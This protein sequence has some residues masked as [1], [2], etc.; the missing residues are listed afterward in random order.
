MNALS[1]IRATVEP[2]QVRM[3]SLQFHVVENPDD[4][5]NFAARELAGKIRKILTKHG[6]KFDLDS[7]RWENYDNGDFY[8]V[9]DDENPVSLPERSKALAAGRELKKVFEDAGFQHEMNFDPNSWVRELYK[10]G[11]TE[12]IATVEPQRAVSYGEALIKLH[13]HIGKTRRPNGLSVGIDVPGEK[14]CH[15]SVCSTGY[16]GSVGFELCVWSPELE[17][18]DTDSNWKSTGESYRVNLMSASYDPDD[19]SSASA[20]E[21]YRSYSHTKRNITYWLKK[22]MFTG[23]PQQDVKVLVAAAAKAFDPDFWKVRA[24]VNGGNKLVSVAV[25]LKAKAARS[26]T[27]A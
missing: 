17:T 5:S 18:E 14:Q 20:W 22:A 12:V 24:Y 9:G 6:F 16:R 4:L 7:A 2:I 15:V 10:H 3:D 1:L 21:A 19:P 26:S 23:R 25:A 13:E 8:Q 27:N 11:A